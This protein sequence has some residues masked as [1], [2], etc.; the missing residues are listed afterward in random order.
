MEKLREST[1]SAE[2]D[3]LKWAS[4]LPF[5]IIVDLAFGEAFHFIVEGNDH[6]NRIKVLNERGEWSATVGTMPWINHYAVSILGQF[7]PP[8]Y[9]E[10]S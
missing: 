2:F 1:G 9:T 8:D 10:C 5:D 7:L 3:F 6:N 4:Y